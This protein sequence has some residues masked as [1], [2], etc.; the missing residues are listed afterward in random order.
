MLKLVNFTGVVAAAKGTRRCAPGT[1]GFT[2]GNEARL[3]VFAEPPE[4]PLVVCLIKTRGIVFAA[5]TGSGGRGAAR[6][7]VWTLPVWG[8]QQSK[9]NS[10]HRGEG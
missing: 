6:V 4:A 8:R 1:F 5:E 9:S 2:A 10:R 3:G 7:C